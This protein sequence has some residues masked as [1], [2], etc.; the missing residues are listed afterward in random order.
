MTIF[1][2]IAALIVGVFLGVFIAS[3]MVASKYQQ[4]PPLPPAEPKTFGLAELERVKNVLGG[5]SFTDAKVVK[6][7]TAVAEMEFTALDEIANNRDDLA[8]NTGTK[9]MYI[10]TYRRQITEA[11]SAIAA[12][13]ARDTELA[14][15]ADAFAG[16]N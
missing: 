3:L 9:N 8:S 5:L 7:A 1:A 15:L 6:V 2:S 14:S 4:Q 10:E 11:E 13:T 16:T 12:N